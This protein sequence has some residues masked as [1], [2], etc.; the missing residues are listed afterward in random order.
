MSRKIGNDKRNKQDSVTLERPVKIMRGQ[1][2]GTYRQSG[3]IM[4]QVI[5][6]PVIENLRRQYNNEKQIV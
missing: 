4:E 1:C 5:K 2:Q 3:K 6:Q